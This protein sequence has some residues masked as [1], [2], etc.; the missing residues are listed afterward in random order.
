MLGAEQAPFLGSPGGEDEGAIRP[1]AS[2]EG[3]GEFQNAGNAER[4]VEPPG[5]TRLPRASGAPTAVGI[6]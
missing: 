5:R 3:A 1:R 4:V 2:L 6:Q